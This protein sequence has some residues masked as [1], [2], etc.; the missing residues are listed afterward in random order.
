MHLLLLPQFARTSVRIR[1]DPWYAPHM[2][3]MLEYAHACSTHAR[4]CK[5]MQTGRTKRD[6]DRGVHTYYT[7]SRLRKRFCQLYV[8]AGVQSRIARALQSAS[9]PPNHPIPTTPGRSSSRSH[10]GAIVCS[11]VHAV[12]HHSRR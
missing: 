4:A 11:A 6:E 9:A 10:H 2:V 8:V 1:I 12:C 7:I 5:R 3:H